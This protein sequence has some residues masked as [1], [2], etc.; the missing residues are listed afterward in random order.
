MCPAG[1]RCLQPGEIAGYAM[2]DRMTKHLVTQALLRAVA[3]RWPPAG[4]IR[5]TDRGS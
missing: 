2:S 4:L 5:H 3:T 1:L